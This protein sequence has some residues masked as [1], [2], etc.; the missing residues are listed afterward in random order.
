MAAG[1]GWWRDSGRDAAN[2]SCFGVRRG[3]PRPL[4][5][6]C[7]KAFVFR[8]FFLRRLVLYCTEIFLSDR[9][10][11]LGQALLGFRFLAVSLTSFS[12]KAPVVHINSPRNPYSSSTRL[13]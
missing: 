11:G 2:E 9:A 10:R 4:A 6:V 8:V 5:S 13:G 7:H 3:A 1:V 12:E